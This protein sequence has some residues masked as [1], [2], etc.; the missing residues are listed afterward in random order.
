[1]LSCSTLEAMKIW[2][3]LVECYYGENKYASTEAEI[4]SYR[5]ETYTP[6]VHQ[7]NAQDDRALEIAKEAALS[8]ASIVEQ[9]CVAYKSTVTIEGKSLRTF[10]NNA[11][12]GEGLMVRYHV[13]IQ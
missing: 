12:R 3:E 1:M 6:S 2:G 5:L 11:K 4:Y 9:F 7:M 8:L 13:E 10:R